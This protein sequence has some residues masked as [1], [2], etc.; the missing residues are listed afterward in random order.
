MNLNFN[1]NEIKNISIPFPIGEFH[2]SG[3]KVSRSMIQRSV[4]RWRVNNNWLIARNH[5]QNFPNSQKYEIPCFR[6][7]RS[8]KNPPTTAFF[9]TSLQIILSTKHDNFSNTTK[10]VDLVV[11]IVVSYAS[12]LNRNYSRSGENALSSFRFAP[13]SVTR[14]RNR[15]RE[16]VKKGDESW[17]IV[18]PGSARVSQ[19]RER[20]FQ[21]NPTELS[22][23]EES[24]P[25]ILASQTFSLLDRRRRDTLPTLVNFKRYISLYTR[26]PC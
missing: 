11:R 8:S 22:L 16:G 20:A 24:P 14:S 5:R 25:K 18:I 21:I 4:T 26:H 19:K 2:P 15:R 17:A 3:G 10:I 7:G 6:S 23:P 9:H 1:I 13:T 12:W